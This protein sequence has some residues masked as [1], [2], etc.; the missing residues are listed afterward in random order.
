[1]VQVIAEE[2]QA[3]LSVGHVWKVLKRLKVCWGLLRPVVSYP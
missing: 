2:L 1:M 3:V